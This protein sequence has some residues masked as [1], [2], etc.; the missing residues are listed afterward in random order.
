MRRLPNQ[1]SWTYGF[2]TNLATLFLAN[3]ILRVSNRPVISRPFTT[4]VSV[5]RDNFSRNLEGPL[6]TTNVFRIPMFLMCLV[7]FGTDLQAQDHCS[8]VV[9]VVNS[10]GNE[11]ATRVTVEERDGRK[12]EKQGN[13]ADDLTF[14]DLGLLPVTVI[15]GYP[16]CSQVVV[17]NVPLQW[18]ETKTL[19]VMVERETCVVR[20]VISTGIGCEFLV[21]F[22]DSQRRYIEGVSLAMR[23]PR[24]ETRQADRY[25]RLLVR[26]AGGQELLGTGS[27]NGYSPVEVRVPCSRENAVFEQYAVMNETR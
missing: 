14:C 7:W 18:G 2:Y 11:V 5:R 23:A 12:I 4:I 10:R 16:A 1:H 20:D 26:L 17:R 21:R 15:V 27:A 9:K 19:K 8:L 22:V 3:G 13:L 6:S 24:Q 25:G